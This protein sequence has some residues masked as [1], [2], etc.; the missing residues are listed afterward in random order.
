MRARRTEF[1]YRHRNYYKL[2][3]AGYLLTASADSIRTVTATIA[4]EI[5][6]TLDGSDWMP[7][8]PE[9][10]PVYPIIVNG[11]SYLPVRLL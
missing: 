11:T 1:A 3:P 4:S 6:R 7:I 2:V 5:H 8:N 9:H 10:Q